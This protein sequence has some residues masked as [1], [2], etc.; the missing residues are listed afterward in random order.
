MAIVLINS[1]L[2]EASN[3]SVI[4]PQVVAW[5]TLIYVVKFVSMIKEYQCLK[6]VSSE[7][8]Q[9]FRI[10]LGWYFKT[11]CHWLLNVRCAVFRRDVAKQPL[12]RFIR[13][14]H[15][16][17]LARFIM[18]INFKVNSTVC[19]NLIGV[20]WLALTYELVYS[21]ANTDCGGISGYPLKGYTGV[22]QHDKCDYSIFG[23]PTY[24]T[25][26]LIIKSCWVQLLH[27][28]YHPYYSC[29]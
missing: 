19:A 23:S 3:A 8:K 2:Y 26:S 1:K 9:L 24:T 16:T 10:V 7:L 12:C 29:V 15:K 4:K 18:S 13:Q 28:H 25:I 14:A 6:C 21:I 5:Q 27:N 22:Y 20:H 11:Y 17:L